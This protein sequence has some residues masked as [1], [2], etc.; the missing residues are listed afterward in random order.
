MED[1]PDRVEEDLPSPAPTEDVPEVIVDKGTTS[2]RPKGQ[3]QS[4]DALT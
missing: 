2:D 4:S 3:S 1:N